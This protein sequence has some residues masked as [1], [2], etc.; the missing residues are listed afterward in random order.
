[1]A[2]DVCLDVIVG[3]ADYMGGSESGEVDI[4]IDAALVGRGLL[5]CHIFHHKFP[6]NERCKTAPPSQLL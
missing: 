3:V 4:E 6:L 1:M 2:S 5:L